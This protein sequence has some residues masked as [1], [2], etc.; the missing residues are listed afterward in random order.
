MAPARAGGE[1][2][3]PITRNEADAKQCKKSFEHRKP[4]GCNG[5]KSLPRIADR[6]AVGA[7][8]STEQ[9]TGQ[10][11]GGASQVNVHAP[12]TVQ[13]SSGT[14]EQNAD[15]AKQMGTKL[16]TVARTIVVD[17][18]RRSHSG[19]IGADYSVFACCGTR[20]MAQTWIMSPSSNM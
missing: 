16:E 2:A 13:G 9:G 8:L 6:G 15:L 11:F 4:L 20:P 5:L 3:S 14:P 17:E 7:D 12:V 18:I 1:T 10:G 19:G